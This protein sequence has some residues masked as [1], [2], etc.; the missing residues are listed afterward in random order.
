MK[1]VIKAIVIFFIMI[2]FSYSSV[3]IELEK[4][5]NLLDQGK[6]S[7]DQFEKAKDIL[8]KIEDNKKKNKSSVEKKKLKE[9][10]IIIRQFNRQA[11]ASDKF[12]KM[13]MIIGDYRIYTHR[14][15][16]M[17][18]KKI[19]NGKQLAVY[20]DKMDLKF[21]N[22]GEKYFK[23]EKINEN[24]SVIKFNDVPVLLTDTRYVSKHKAHFYQ[25]LALGTKP[26]HYYIKLPNKSPIALN[27]KKFDRKIKKAVE[28]AKVRLASTHNVTIDQINLIMKKRDEKAFAELEN[29]IGKK[30]EE[31]IEAAIDNSVDELLNQQLEL[32]L[33]AALANEF[34]SA[35]EA[36]TGQAIDQ[37]LENE[38]AKAIDE[39]VAAAISEGISAAAI[40]AGIAAY[41]AAIAAGASEADAYAAGEAACGC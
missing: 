9:N 34:I 24:R 6:I 25:V 20:G 15:G 1:L 14:P 13:E 4:L 18:I 28:K 29:I 30:R 22:D 32:A 10:N 19:S 36:Q 27:Y 23:N 35:I 38:L 37:A 40:Q 3:V 2:S 16:G 21:Y 5:S 17:K 26:F 39:V 31:V 12:E 7:N 8:L 41:L 11:A 33:G